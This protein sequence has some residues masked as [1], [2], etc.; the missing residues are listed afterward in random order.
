MTRTSKNK[1][2][3]VFT[4]IMGPNS[5]AYKVLKTSPLQNVIK[6]FCFFALSVSPCKIM[7]SV[8]IFL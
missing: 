2:E 1:Q 3:H 5:G 4:S 6:A 8:Q 7:G